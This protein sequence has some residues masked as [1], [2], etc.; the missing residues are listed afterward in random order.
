MDFQVGDVI[1]ITDTCN[2]HEKKCTIKYEILNI[3]KR[4]RV[5][6]IVEDEN[7]DC[8]FFGTHYC[9]SI[10]ESIYNPYLTF[11]KGTYGLESEDYETVLYNLDEVKIISI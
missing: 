4:I 8:E 7:F 11:F 5:E 6:S 1:A 3:G 9:S 10:E 2:T